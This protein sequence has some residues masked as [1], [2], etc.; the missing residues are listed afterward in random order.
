[1]GSEKIV[2]AP[3]SGGVDFDHPAAGKV[4]ILNHA[5]ARID[6]GG[7]KKIAVCGF[8]SSSSR[9]A[10][11]DDPEYIILGLNQ[12][13]RHIPRADAWIEIH[14]EW[15]EHVIEG[16]DHEGWLQSFPGPIYMSERIPNIPNS[17]RYPIERAIDM[18]SDY[19]TS[20]IAFGIAVGIMEGFEEI[21]IY[22]VDLI[23]G[24]EYFHQKACVEYMIG[25]A[26]AKGINVRLPHKTALCK[27]MYR[28]GYEKEPD[29]GP[30]TMTNISGRL[31]ILK[32]DH[33]KALARAHWLTGRLNEIESLNG[34]LEAEKFAERKEELSNERDEHLAALHM[35]EGAAR[36]TDRW[37][38]Y[39]D[40]HLRGGDIPIIQ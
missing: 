3:S 28:Y 23:V 8:A 39:L 9:E 38:E 7:R 35:M 1:M 22:G 4:T 12:L 40:L 32:E 24:E 37:R 33:R 18:F 26:N 34:S 29:W 6:W 5:D 14:R 11:F 2:H 15:N 13:Y 31:D 16:T 21:A 30:M 19:F 25:F 17:V 36:E 27:Q 20:T 10:P